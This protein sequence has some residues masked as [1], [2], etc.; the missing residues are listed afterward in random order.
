MVAGLEAMHPAAAAIA[1]HV[2]RLIPGGASALLFSKPIETRMV[3][4]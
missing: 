3:A 1:D 4:G 2:A